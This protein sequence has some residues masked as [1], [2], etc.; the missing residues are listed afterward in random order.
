MIPATVL[1][2]NTEADVEGTRAAYDTVAESY[3][4]LLRDEL[5]RA[6]WD[7]AMLDA[8]AELVRE[9]GGG[10]V[11]DLGCGPGRMTAYLHGLGTDVFGV[12]LSPGMVAVARARH[13]ELRFEVGSM[14]GLDLP[15]GSLAGVVAWYSTVH[16]PPAALPEV[17]AEF[18]RVL[19]PGG[20]LLHAYKVG[21]AHHH[22]DRAYGHD[23]SLDVYWTPPE[24]V[25]GLLADAGLPVE[26]ELI[27]EPDERERPTQGRQGYVVARKP[28]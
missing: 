27:R 22:R 15:D 18:S 25:V 5:A 16:T 23:V 26:A 24:T 13:P 1:I 2:M 12:D 14:T 6:P 19:A 17:F 9:S 11:A 10:P 3:E 7:R 20:R 8:F 28:V 21:D 4:R